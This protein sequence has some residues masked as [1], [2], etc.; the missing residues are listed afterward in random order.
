[1]E[2]NQIK[3][4]K[5]NDAQLKLLQ[6]YKKEQFELKSEIHSD[7]A[8]M[9]IEGF[10][11]MRELTQNMAIIAGAIASF[12]IPILNTTII[13]T[14]WLA[15]SAVM[16]LFGTIIYAVYHL[17]EVIPKEI[18]ELSKQHTTYNELLDESI[19]RI[20]KTISTGDA[21]ELDNF[22][23]E[24]VIK[25]VA[26]LKTKNRR[27]ASLNILRTVLFL[28]LIFLSFSFIP[29]NSITQS[30][31]RFSLLKNTNRLT[32][33]IPKSYNLSSTNPSFI[34]SGNN[35]VSTKMN[36]S[37]KDNKIYWMKDLII[38]IA[39]TIIAL[40]LWE[41]FKF[42]RV[43]VSAPLIN[44]YFQKNGTKSDT[45][46]IPQQGAFNLPIYIIARGKWTHIP[47]IGW[48]V[49]K[50]WTVLVNIIVS[51]TID[52]YSLDKSPRGKYL[53]GK[54]LLYNDGPHLL[55]SDAYGIGAKMKTPNTTAQ[56]E[57]EVH[58]YL[59]ERGKPFMIKKLKLTH[60]I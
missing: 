20:N 49:E 2:I 29:F 22:D 54:H 1:M 44:I 40:M 51:D 46:S 10:R 4:I 23:K 60:K 26:L 50:K 13:Q 12:T 59:E 43:L 31:N 16:L 19:N 34:K 30:I 5:V 11:Q 32:Q 48:I 3:E 36:I 18:N 42:I 47:V 52:I 9:L 39:T 37:S 35:P 57:L 28:A 33:N 17:S 56:T 53:L 41:T 55:G 27:D 38:P 58:V 45:F 25:R 8:P 6:Q 7:I 14:R 24:E 21:K 15:Y